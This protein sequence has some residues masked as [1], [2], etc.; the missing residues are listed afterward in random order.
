MLKLGASFVV[1]TPDTACELA[2]A[3]GNLVAVF[4]K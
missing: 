4:K 2:E 3:D 1:Q